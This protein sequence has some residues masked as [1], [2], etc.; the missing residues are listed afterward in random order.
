MIEKS[1]CS[2]AGCDRD[3]YAKQLCGSHYAQ[4]RRGDGSLSPIRHRFSMPEK[5]AHIG[6]TRDKFS[7]GYCHPH[8][9]QFNRW[10]KTEDLHAPRAGFSPKRDASGERVKVKPCK[11]GSCT[12]RRVKNGF[13][14][15]HLNLW[16]SGRLEGHGEYVKCSILDCP[17]VARS[18]GICQVHRQ[19]GARFSL[20]V[21]QIIELYEASNGK[22][23][24]CHRTLSVSPADKRVNQPHIDHDHS[25]CPS[26]RSC[27]NCVRGI[28]CRGCN[29]SIGSAYDNPEILRELASYLENWRN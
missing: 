10:G 27:G 21:S 13:C 17:G 12:L 5:C 6:C 25:C 3:S 24:T 26:G 7:N 16:L 22:C 14:D 23:K 15:R 1:A 29:M 11:E 20:D 2:F 18:Y 19:Q 4:S 28:L 9:A 8:N